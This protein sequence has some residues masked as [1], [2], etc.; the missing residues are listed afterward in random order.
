MVQEEEEVATESLV[1]MQG[2]R[3]R[4]APHGSHWSGDGAAAAG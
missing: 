2:R 3:L 4:G 1:T